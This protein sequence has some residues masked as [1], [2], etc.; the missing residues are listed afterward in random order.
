MLN[1]IYLLFDICY[2]EKLCVSFLFNGEFTYLM[3]TRAIVKYL[4]LITFAA[5]A[6]KPPKILCKYTFF[7]IAC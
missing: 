6:R 3:M 1:L 5:N 2:I 7:V 4:L